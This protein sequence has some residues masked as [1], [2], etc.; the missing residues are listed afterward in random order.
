MSEAARILFVGQLWEG[1]TSLDRMKALTE[2]GYE[3]VPFDTSPY[4]REGIRLIRSLTHRLMWGSAVNR[5]NDD[6]IR[7]SRRQ[8][9]SHTWIEKGIWIYAETIDEIK[10][11]SSPKVIHYTPDTQL[12]FNKSRHFNAAIP[13]YDCLF[14]TKP[15]EIDLYRK[16]G[17]RRI[18]LTFQGYDSSRFQPY[19]PGSADRERY[20]TDVC[21]VG[22]YERHYASMVQAALKVTPAV[23]VW[24]P[25]WTR[26]ARFWP[27]AKRYVAGD[28]VW[29][30]DY[31]VA[32]NSAKICL[33]L[34]SKWFPET[35]TTRTFEIPACGAFMLA[36]RTPEHQQLFQEGREAEYFSSTDELVEKTKFY[37]ANTAAR[38]RIANAGRERC[39][40]SGYS[41]RERIREILEVGNFIR[42]H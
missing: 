41:N 28:G 36:E 4:Y 24:G 42:G 12:V 26:F 2:L 32:L 15:F 5:L 30:R 10:R 25:R 8:S 17:A 35:T 16:K 39:V 7:A 19:S 3:V 29:G 1:S 18:F 23:K 22:H 11:H 33:G 37:L 31:V 40:R 38:K 20:G 13:K 9:V 27:P 34:L 14:T 21:F 6:L